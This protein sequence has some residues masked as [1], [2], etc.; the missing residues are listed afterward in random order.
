MGK[1]TLV[2]PTMF[3]LEGLCADELRKLDFEDVRAENGRVLFSADEAGV[4]RANLCLRTG[5]RVLLRLG[6]F[7]AVT[8]DE[9]F[10]GVA[11]L[12]LEDYIPKTGAFPVKGYCLDSKL[13]AM[14][15]CQSI[16]KKASAKRLGEHY[17]LETLP[18]TGALYQL[19][20]SIMKD[21]AELYLDTS[22]PGLHKRGYRAI[23]VVAPIRET[24]AAAMVILSKYRGR[25]PFCDPFCGSGTIPIEAAMIAKNQAPGLDRSFSAQKWDFLPKDIWLEEGDRA[26][27]AEFSGDYD[28]WGG[29]IDPKA[30]AIA[31]H[32]AEMAG[33]DHLVRFEEADA[34]K[35]HRD[36]PYGRVVTNPPYGERIMDK[37]EA[38][39]LYAAFGTAWR[40]MP[41][42]WSLYLLSSHTEFERTFGAQADKKRKLYNGMIKCDL[43]MYGKRGEKSHE[44]NR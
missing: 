2:A 39:G 38:E 17:G 19:Q 40:D 7:P 5:E 31:K 41:P 33:V 16:I 6:R 42:G 20:F 37:S 28:I 10:E 9:L 32:N 27:A 11:A 23:G 15:A 43:F 44:R 1:F 22:G 24:L 3:G 4:A 35:F 18:E 8:F 12:P 14:S 34:T 13:F 30:V 36:D 29:D 26:M 21:V 25:D